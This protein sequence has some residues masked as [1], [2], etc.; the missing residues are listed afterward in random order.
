VCQEILLKFDAYR[1]EG[2]S[3]M[4]AVTRI[5]EE[6][7][8]APRTVHALLQRLQPTTDIAKMYLKAKAFRLAKRL[9]NKASPA[10]A[11]D[12]LERPGMNVLEP[13]KKVEG[14]GGGFFLS[15]QTD[16][17]GAVKVGVATGQ[18]MPQL[19]ATTPDFNPYDGLSKETFDEVTTPGDAGP[20]RLTSHRQAL[21]DGEAESKNRTLEAA[22]AKLQAA[23][24]AAEAIDT[25][26]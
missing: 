13:T 9:V 4:L 26:D 16:T 24:A 6:T 12:I 15:V 20:R 19:P 2:D 25:K 1:R 8:L 3:I 17:C 10:E 5:G 23:R 22:R 7:K 14:G 11:I 18:A 21:T